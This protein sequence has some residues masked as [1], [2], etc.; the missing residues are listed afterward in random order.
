MNYIEP[1]CTNNVNV[2]GKP[3]GTTALVSVHG[4]GA[5][6]SAWRDVAMAFLAAYRVVLL[7]NA[8]APRTQ[9]RSPSTAI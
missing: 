8:P 2:L 9:P 6:Q 3:D 4:F 1:I 7:D 5:D